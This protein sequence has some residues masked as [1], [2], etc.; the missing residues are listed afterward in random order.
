[1]LKEEFIS[2]TLVKHYS[3][4]GFLIKQIE[5]GTLYAEAVDLRPCRYTYEETDEPINKPEEEFEENSD[6]IQENEDVHTMSLPRE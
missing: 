2:E 4:E 1:M 6:E 3:D 5:T